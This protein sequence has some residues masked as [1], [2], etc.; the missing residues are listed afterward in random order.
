MGVSFCLCSEPSWPY[1]FHEMNL[2]QSRPPYDELFQN[3][4]INPLML[5]LTVVVAVG[6]GIN[7]KT[8]N[9]L[10]LLLYR[11]RTIQNTKQSIKQQGEKKATWRQNCA[12][13][14][15]QIGTAF[16]LFVFTSQK[17]TIMLQTLHF[18]EQKTSQL[19]VFFPIM[20]YLSSEV[21]GRKESTSERYF[22]LQ[23]RLLFHFGL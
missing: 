17:L 20:Q 19:F 9:C 4:A 13:T 8:L 16:V 18:A 7:Y 23:T 12:Q 5:L 22:M 2:Y 6:G 14:L 21:T 1:S 10:C 3:K 11:Q 15:P